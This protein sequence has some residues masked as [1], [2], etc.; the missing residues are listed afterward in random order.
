MKDVQIVQLDENLECWKQNTV[1]SQGGVMTTGKSPNKGFFL[2]MYSNLVKSMIQS[3]SNNF[4][5]GIVCKAL[6]HAGI[7]RTTTNA[8]NALKTL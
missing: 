2:F 7:V 1:M 8:T 3:M 5:G 4:I 6:N